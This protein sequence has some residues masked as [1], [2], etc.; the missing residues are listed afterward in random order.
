MK[1][2]A[3]QIS[4][5]YDVGGI[6]LNL[7]N[8]EEVKAAYED[9]MTNI[10]IIEPEAKIEGV[11]LQSMLTGGMEVIIGMVQDL[12]FRSHVNVWTGWYIC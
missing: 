3:T 9:M 11:Q 5:K 8:V 6:K 12:H 1:V 7:K 2:V 4:H 10:P